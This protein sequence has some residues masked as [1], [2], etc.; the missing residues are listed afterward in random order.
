M[1]DMFLD[2]DG[3]MELGG[4]SQPLRLLKDYGA[5]EADRREH[6]WKKRVPEPISSD[7]VRDHWND[8]P[9]CFSRTTC[10]K[11]KDTRCERGDL[12]YTRELHN[13]CF[14]HALGVGAVVEGGDSIHPEG[15][16]Q[17]DWPYDIHYYEGRQNYA[18]RQ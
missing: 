2:R 13:C 12:R 6:S 14:F 9:G 11:V 17:K 15:C 7:I 18:A 4:E 16:T 1:E 3:S 5:E 10:K 8:P